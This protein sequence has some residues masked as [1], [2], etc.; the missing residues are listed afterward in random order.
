MIIN[1]VHTWLIDGS[2]NNAINLN[3][4][5]HLFFNNAPMTAS[6]FIKT[7]AS[8]MVKM[9]HNSL[10]VLF[11]LYHL[12]TWSLLFFKELREMI[13][14]HPQKH[15]MVNLQYLFNISCSLSNSKNI[16]PVRDSIH[17]L[18]IDWKQVHLCLENT[19][20]P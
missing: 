4:R 9:L 1:V 6:E 17:S 20:I 11:R 13:E 2:V 16:V 7:T 18:F 8:K 5:K 14:Y 3:I 10:P 19:S 12:C 15:N